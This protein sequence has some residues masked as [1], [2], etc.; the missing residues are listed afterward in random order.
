MNKFVLKASEVNGC[1]TIFGR[2]LA[3]CKFDYEKLVRLAADIAMGTRPFQPSLSS[4]CRDFRIRP[5]DLRAELKAR[6]AAAHDLG[7]Q[8]AAELKRGVQPAH[9]IYDL[10]DAFESLSDP[11][12]VE[13]FRHIGIGRVF[14]ALEKVDSH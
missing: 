11:E 3:C 14:E 4:I 2:S 1:G 9:V 13:A 12:R 10:V 8:L 6:A 7:E 5:V